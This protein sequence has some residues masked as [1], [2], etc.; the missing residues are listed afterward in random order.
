MHM[1]KTLQS[2]I[3]RY[4]ENREI[5]YVSAKMIGEQYGLVFRNESDLLEWKNV[6]DRYLKTFEESAWENIE[7]YLAD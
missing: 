5:D 1:D 7:N 6:V 4:V 3:H 2:T